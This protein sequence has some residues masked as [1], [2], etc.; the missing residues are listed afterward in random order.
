[1]SQKRVS[2]RE[3]KTGSFEYEGENKSKRAVGNVLIMT[4]AFI[5]FGYRNESGSSSS[6]HSSWNLNGRFDACVCRNFCMA[7][8]L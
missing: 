3:I 6:K 5:S 4:I 8:L 1:M 7:V 2:G